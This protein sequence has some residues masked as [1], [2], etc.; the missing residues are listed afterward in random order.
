VIAWRPGALA[1]ALGAVLATTACGYTAGTGW[2]ERGVHTLAVRVVENGT[3]RQGLE[4]P[5]TEEVLRQLV[6]TDLLP[7]TES[8]ADAILEVEITNEQGRSIVSGGRANPVREG[9]LELIVHAR[10]WD[11]RSGRTLS[12]RHLIDRAE[13]RTPI[14]QD[15]STATSELVSDLARK[16]V[17]ALE[18]PF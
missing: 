5:L 15:L 13:Y 6:R 14:G 10:V 9:S 18:T 7:G 16:I 11:R 8:S 12:T 3:F 4:E 17:L 1:A 2:H